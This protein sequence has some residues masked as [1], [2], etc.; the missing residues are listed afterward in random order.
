MEDS[1]GLS[2]ERDF[3]AGGRLLSFSSLSDDCCSFFSLLGLLKSDAV[4]GVLGVLL[5]LPKLA[6]A[7]LPNPNADDAPEPVG[8]ATEVADVAAAA[9]NGLFLLERL[10]NRF[11][12]VVS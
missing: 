11:A 10:P 3:R 2:D 4:P 12:E 9:L 5:A 1:D 7:P 6:K 8:E